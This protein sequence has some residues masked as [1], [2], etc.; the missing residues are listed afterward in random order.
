MSPRVTG[1]LTEMRVSRSCRAWAEWV[2]PEASFLL[3]PT[4]QRPVQPSK[5][6]SC[7]S[8]VG[9][10][11][12]I[13]TLVWLCPFCFAEPSPAGC[14]PLSTGCPVAPKLLPSPCPTPGPRLPCCPFSPQPAH[15][16][17]M[18]GRKGFSCTRRQPP[19]PTPCLQ[20]AMTRDLMAASADRPG[21]TNV[22]QGARCSRC[23][24][25]TTT[26]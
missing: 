7:G 26:S 8:E 9:R 24:V 17:H 11:T 15:L 6:C 23:G 14:R 16:P 19:N 12:G 20:N 25:P 1:R 4:L 3:I 18:R 21:R 22:R 10:T 2:Y 13:K 5:P